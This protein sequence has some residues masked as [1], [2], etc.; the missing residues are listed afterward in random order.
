MTVLLRSEDVGIGLIHGLKF[1]GLGLELCGSDDSI[2]GF[3]FRFDIDSIF[4]KY[5]RYRF[6]INIL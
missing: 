5:L 6:D 4:A 1:Y 3:Q 2:S